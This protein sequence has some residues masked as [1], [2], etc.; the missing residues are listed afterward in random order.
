LNLQNL[1]VKSQRILG[2]Q[3]IEKDFE[4]KENLPCFGPF[5]AQL[6][7]SPSQP[8]PNR[9]RPISSHRRLPQERKQLRVEAE[10]ARCRHLTKMTAAALVRG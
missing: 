6:F 1:F 10:A 3:K 5:P 4:K 2:K 9:G 8:K 7:P